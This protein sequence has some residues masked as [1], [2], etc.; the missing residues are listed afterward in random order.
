MLPTLIV[1]FREVLEA[2]LVVGIVAA[3]TKGV[4]G[5]S[6]WIGLGIAVGVL[7]AGLEAG[8]ARAISD[9]AQGMG[10]ELFN[11]TIL[12][13]A[14]LMLGWHNVWMGKH[15]REI[16]A[17]A[18]AIGRAVRAGTRPLYAVGIVVGVA[19]LREGS[20]VVLF[21][22]GI[23]AADPGHAASML[24]GGLIGLALGVA[25]GLA[26]YSGLAR[27]PMRHLFR[28]TSW[29][30]TLLAAGLAS[31]GAG[32]LM[33]AGVLPSVG[34]TLW[35]TSWLLSQSSIPGLVLHTLV[36]Y[37]AQPDGLQLIF[38]VATIVGIVGLMRL[39]SAG[40]K[41]RPPAPSA[42]PAPEAAGE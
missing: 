12:F 7:L 8:F 27:I 10:Q 1:V 38:Y 15:G 26:T 31:Q 14:V 40:A 16:A 11:A 20:E 21:L 36:G 25:V 39:V 4:A 17:D 18:Q 35:D 29:M 5:R 6:F 2:A 24:V 19:V 13:A 34:G 42:Q 30:I 28:V 37:T 3:A 9:M 22:Y 41:S 32:F 33:A 23:A